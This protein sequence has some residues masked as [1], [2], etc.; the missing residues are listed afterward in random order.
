MATKFDSDA[1]RM[2]AD[3][4]AE[5]GEMATCVPAN[6]DPSYRATVVFH[7][8]TKR[9]AASPAR[10]IQL[11]DA[12]PDID[13]PAAQCATP[14]AIDDRWTL[15]DDPDRSWRVCAPPVDLSG[16]RVHLPLAEV[17]G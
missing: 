16:D 17:I 3:V 5:F 6:G 9:A 2:H 11:V 4:E 12:V 15:D 7:D 8:P 14:P 10:A 13:V 1:D